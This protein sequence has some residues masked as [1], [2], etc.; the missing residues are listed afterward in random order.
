[1]SRVQ[2]VDGRGRD[3]RPRN[4]SDAD[5][6]SRSREGEVVHRNQN[7]WERAPAGGQLSLSQVRIS[8]DVRAAGLT[9]VEPDGLTR[10][11]DIIS[12]PPIPPEKAWS[13][14]M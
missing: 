1:M 11:L 9:I 10:T 8:Q 6:A 12:R 5:V 3:S 13:E 2:H 14:R 4:P 7:A